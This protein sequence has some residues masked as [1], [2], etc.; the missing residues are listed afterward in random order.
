MAEDNKLPPVTGQQ[1]K[2]DTN[3]DSSTQQNNNQCCVCFRTYK[4]DQ[5]E[6]T[7]FLWV[8]CVCQHWIHED[9]Y[10]EVV[11]DRHG[12][13]LICPYCVMYD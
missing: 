5:E 7:G 12:R 9:C 6:D 3:S 13:E 4:E 8:Q 2:V 1:N 11:M 10:S